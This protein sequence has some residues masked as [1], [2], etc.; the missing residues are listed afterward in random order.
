MYAFAIFWLAVGSLKALTQGL[1][2]AGDA[3]DEIKNLVLK[4]IPILRRIFDPNTA[5]AKALKAKGVSDEVADSAA[6]LGADILEMLINP[7]AKE[8]NVSA[9]PAD[10][11]K[12]AQEEATKM[13]RGGGLL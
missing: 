10:V 3:A 2:L 7:V 4:F 6:E 1:P 9:P 13:G 5:L 8:V 11:A 12:A